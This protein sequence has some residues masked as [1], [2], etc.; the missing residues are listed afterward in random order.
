MSFN[1]IRGN[2]NVR[3][4]VLLLII[5]IAAGIWYYSDSKAAKTAALVGGAVATVAVGFEV[6]DTDF[7]LQT[8]W[9]TG[10]LK[11]SL[12]QR[13]EDGNLVAPASVFCDAQAE[14]YYDYNCSDFQTQDEAQRIYEACDTDINRLD[15][16]KD[17]LV[18]ETLPSA[19]N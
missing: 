4:I 16:D 9:E 12:L 10:S 13:D 18:C 14:G 6:A 7:D 19:Q 15:G 8:L 11:E 2:K 3:L 17:G 5:L 1:K